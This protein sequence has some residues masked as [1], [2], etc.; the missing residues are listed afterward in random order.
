[1]TRRKKSNQPPMNTEGHGSADVGNGF[2]ELTLTE[3]SRH[4]N[5]FI[6]GHLRPSVVFYDR[7][8]A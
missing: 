6:C 3:N 8:I 2:H 7:V 5:V 4:S 1:M